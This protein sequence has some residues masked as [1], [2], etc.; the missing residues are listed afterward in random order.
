MKGKSQIEDSHTIIII[1]I[2]III[3]IYIYIVETGGVIYI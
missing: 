3:Y 1:I 2:I